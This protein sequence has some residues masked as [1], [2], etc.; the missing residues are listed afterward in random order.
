MPSQAAK[1]AKEGRAAAAAGTVRH[2]A[3]RASQAYR[4][5]AARAVRHRAWR[6]A[7]AGWASTDLPLRRSSIPTAWCAR[8]ARSTCT[9]PDPVR[10]TG[11]TAPRPRALNSG[12]VTATRIRWLAEAWW[13][14]GVWRR[15]RCRSSAG[16]SRGRVRRL[17][18][19][20]PWT[21]GRWVLKAHR[22]RRSVSRR[23]I[24]SRRRPVGR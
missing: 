6:Q 23:V 11:T 5:A 13:N 19:R 15:R 3:Y 16:K 2:R 8:T 4:A 12:T 1:A 17:P 21:P 20:V 14:C 18:R 9:W 24:R 22:R 10:P 7:A